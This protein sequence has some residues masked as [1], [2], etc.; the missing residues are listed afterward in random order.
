MGKYIIVSPS[1]PPDKTVATVRMSSFVQFILSHNEEVII[2]TNKKDECMPINH[3]MLTYVFVEGNTTGSGL[4]VFNSNSQMYLNAVANILKYATIN[5]ILVSM[6]PFYTYRIALLAKQYSVKCVM[7]FRDPWVFDYRDAKTFFNFRNLIGL[8]AKISKER[9]CVHAASIVI[10][11]TEGWINTFRK[12]YPNEKNKFYLV[13]NGYDDVLLNSIEL[14]NEQEKNEEIITFG[15]FGKL[16]YY[17]EKYSGIFLDALSKCGAENFFIKQI[18]NREDRTDILLENYKIPKS[19]VFCTGFMNYV[20]GIR[21]LNNSDVL[22]IIDGRKSAI[23]TKIYDYIYLGKPIVYVG[24]RNTAIS[25]IVKKL[26]NGFVCSNI[27]EMERAFSSLK[28]G[29]PQKRKGNNDYSRTKQNER[30]YGL[31]KQSEGLK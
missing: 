5:G 8:I 12:F 17:T 13:E 9:Q 31:L 27:Q 24:P 4:E 15:V 6:G 26:D 18:G 23:G 1:F 25:S 16:F 3:S 21:E 14:T 10:T 2:V 20:D 22:L 7:D 28:N 11:V 30:L 29:I 19:K